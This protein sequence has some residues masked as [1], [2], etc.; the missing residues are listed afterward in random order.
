MTARAFD[1]VDHDSG[2]N[3]HILAD[4][5]SRSLLARL[6]SPACD[7]RD[8]HPL[9]DACSAVLLQAAVE[10]LPR[11]SV[12]QPTR[13]AAGEPRAVLRE[14]ILDP[15]AP[16]VVV[17][18]ARGGIAPSLSFQRG[19]MQ[20]LDPA[21]VR[22]DHVYL[23]RVADPA[24]GAVTGVSHAGSKLGGPVA[25]AT[26]FVPDPMAATGASMAY[27]LDIYRSM[28]GGPP[29]RIVACHLIATPEYLARIARDAPDVVVY[30]LRV[31]RGLSP[32]DVLAAKP[33]ARW[34]E[35]RGLDAHSYIVPGAGGIGEVLNNAWV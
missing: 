22:V 32:D 7:T 5:W 28:A 19:L 10:Q 12:E 3:V 26:L 17:D 21:S 8:A 15:Q 18:V 13:M 6:C 31:D 27:V 24:T 29:R 35:E 20:V 23:Q 14:S 2:D 4:P 1:R 34:R 33:G 25:G 11:V 9:L 30:A 16:A